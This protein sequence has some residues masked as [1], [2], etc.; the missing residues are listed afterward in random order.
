LGPRYL[1]FLSTI[2]LISLPLV[3]FHARVTMLEIPALATCLAVVHFW[4]RF[5]DNE[6]RRDLWALAGFTV[7]AFLISQKAIFLVLFFV[8]GLVVE[9]RFRL[10]KRLDVWVALLVSL[11]PVVSWYALTFRYLNFTSNVAGSHFDFLGSLG[12]F[13]TYPVHLGDEFG[14]VLGLLV[15]LGL[16][17]ALWKRSAS[18][19]F[20]LT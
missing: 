15:V 20:L 13:T 16:I 3:L 7:A 4:L 2:V 10:L 17:V 11:L 6:R 14:P 9:R 5:L 19:R 8:F 1:A 12:N 18:H